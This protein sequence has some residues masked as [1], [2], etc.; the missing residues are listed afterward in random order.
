MN[1]VSE[2]IKAQ[3]IKANMTP[4]QLAKKCGVSESYILDVES[5]RKI[6]SDE[7]ASRML[8]A[9]GS[10]SSIINDMDMPEAVT[11]ERTVVIVKRNAPEVA[12]RPAEISDAWKDA[13]SGNTC[14]VPITDTAGHT[15]G[16]RLMAAQSRKIEG[17]PA[18]NAFYFIVPDQSMAAFRLQPG[19]LLLCVK[20]GAIRDGLMVFDYRGK[21]VVR[22]V[23][24]MK[25]NKAELFWYEEGE[26]KSTTALSVEMK[27]AGQVIRAEFV[28]EVK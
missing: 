3:R 19:D 22:K 1:R 8:R 27:N 25:N 23:R 24:K 28:P 2:M 4:K 5:G 9:M 17:A 11:P 16:N 18:E 7:T 13:L 15:V 21:R 14:H 12:D 20:T 10:G 6:L 26:L